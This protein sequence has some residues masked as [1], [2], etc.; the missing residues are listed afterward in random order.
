[1]LVELELTLNSILFRLW[2]LTRPY[3]QLK[4]EDAFRELSAYNSVYRITGW[5]SVRL[6]WDCLPGKLL[7]ISCE[8]VAER[9]T[10]CSNW[11]RRFIVERRR[12]TAKSS[13]NYSWRVTITFTNARLLR[14]V[15]FLEINFRLICSRLQERTGDSLV[16]MTLI[17]GEGR[18]LWAIY[19]VRL[20]SPGTW[21]KVTILTC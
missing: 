10:A 7:L 21:L 1:M 6:Q 9:F 8:M 20:P 12:T 5:N 16:S 13:T 2:K 14:I 3:L 19:S 11:I 4:I 15:S 17:Q 18:W